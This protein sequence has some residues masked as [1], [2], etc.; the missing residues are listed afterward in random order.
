MC[1]PTA[2]NQPSRRS[3]SKRTWTTRGRTR[4]RRLGNRS[5]G[6]TREMSQKARIILAAV[7]CVFVAVV[8]SLPSFIRARYPAARN[9]CISTLKQLEGAV[10]FWAMDHNKTTND[11]PTDADLFGSA[12]YIQKRPTCPQGGTYTIGRVG[13]RPRCSIPMHSLDFGWVIVRDETGLPIEGALVTVLGKVIGAE[14]TRTDSNGV[15]RVN[16]FPSSTVDDWAVHATGIAASQAG[17]Q[18]ATS[19]LPAAPWPVWLTLRRASR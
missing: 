10:A 14:P 18:S 11:A 6:T 7:A 8:V 17:Y 19:A 16:P 3:R 9:S 12:A 15:A 1:R 5:R 2:L 13:E 4:K